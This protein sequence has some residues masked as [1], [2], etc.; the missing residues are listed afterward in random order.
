MTSVA[1]AAFVCGRSHHVYEMCRWSLDH[2]QVN[3][4]WKT[5][6]WCLLGLSLLPLLNR[7]AKDVDDH[8]VCRALLFVG[9]G[10]EI[11]L[12]GRIDANI[13]H[14]FFWHQNAPSFIPVEHQLYT[15][16][17]SS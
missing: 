10:L 6:R 9:H 3:H 13:D 5:G 16:F 1:A 8:V 7:S 15:A 12:H 2:R 4:R 14:R 11:V 17:Q